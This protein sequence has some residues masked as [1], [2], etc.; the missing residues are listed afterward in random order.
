MTSNEI[1]FLSVTELAALYRARKLSPV[2]VAKAV[3]ARIVQG[4][5]GRHRNPSVDR[6]GTRPFKVGA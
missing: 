5:A 2:E 3:L 1:G 6:M 4:N